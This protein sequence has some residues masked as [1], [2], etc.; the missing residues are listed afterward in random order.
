MKSYKAVFS[1]SLLWKILA[2]STLIS[3]VVLLYFGREIYQQAPP[4]PAAVVSSNGS[5]IYSLD[6]IQRGQNI[7]Q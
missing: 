3:F 7:W 5:Q 1:T 2:A 4:M 6:D